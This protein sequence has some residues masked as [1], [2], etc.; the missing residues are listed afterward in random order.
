[1]KKPGK[2][3]VLRALLA[4]LKTCPAHDD[5]FSEEKLRQVW[6]RLYHQAWEQDDDDLR[7]PV[8]AALILF[9]SQFAQLLNEAERS[10]MEALV[11]VAIE[12]Y[13]Q[14]ANPPNKLGKLLAATL[15]EST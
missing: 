9:D 2:P 14:K 3:G 6:E 15:K 10:Q 1:M 8:L 12:R 11:N 7:P 4:V 13:Q 5:S